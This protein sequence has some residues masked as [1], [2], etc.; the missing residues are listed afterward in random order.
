MEYLHFQMVPR[1]KESI[2]LK[3]H[4]QN[5]HSFHIPARSKY[6]VKRFCLTWIDSDV[7]SGKII[8]QG[9]RYTPTETFDLET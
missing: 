7:P 6:N 3:R 4:T 8:L 2:L 5:Q 9:K 1:T